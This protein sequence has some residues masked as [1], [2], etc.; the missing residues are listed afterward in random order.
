MREFP[1]PELG[2]RDQQLRALYQQYKLTPSHVYRFQPEE[3]IKHLH[4]L[5]RIS[6]THRQA[7]FSLRTVGESYEHRPIMM[8]SIGE[9][10]RKVLMWT[11]MHGDEPTH[12]TVA[13][14]LMRTL[15]ESE[16]EVLCKQSLL[17]DVNLHILFM[18]NPDGAARDTRENAQRIDINRDAVDFKTP[19]GRVLR[20]VVDEISPDFG[21]NLHNQRSSKK[22]GDSDNVAVLSVL[23]PPLDEEDRVTPQ[24]KA[25]RQIALEMYATGERLVPGHSTRY[26]AGYMSTAFGEW[27]QARGATTVLLEAGGWPESQENWRDELHY[28]TLFN[29][30]LSIHDKSF[31]ETDAERYIDLPLN[32]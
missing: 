11:Q 2:S 22:A 29:A 9:G 16:A 28:V 13:L 8:A 23:A 20:S 18:L 5:E 27:V 25:A 10:S 1:F 26:E 12:T 24:I 6:K 4:E 32:Q 30:L 21:F 19:E 31:A 7:H 3:V 14:A 15:L 17:A